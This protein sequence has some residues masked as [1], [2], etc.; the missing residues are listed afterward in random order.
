MMNKVM[1]VGRITKINLITEIYSLIYVKC[2]YDNDTSIVPVVINS[3]LHDKAKQYLKVDDMLGVQAYILNTNN[4]ISVVAT[5]L[6]FLASGKE[7]LKNE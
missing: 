7:I 5:K 3:A 4:N 1:L 2:D 6:T